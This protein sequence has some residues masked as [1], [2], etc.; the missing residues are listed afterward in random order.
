MR[1]KIVIPTETDVNI[2]LLSS[3]WLFKF[4]PNMPREK[5]KKEEIN[6]GTDSI[7][8]MVSCCALKKLNKAS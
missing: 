1:V 3:K 2:R 6:A 5:K 4:I 7:A 8:N